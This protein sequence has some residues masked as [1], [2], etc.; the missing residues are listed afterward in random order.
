VYVRNLLSA[1]TN[2]ISIAR[3][4]AGKMCAASGCLIVMVVIKMVEFFWETCPSKYQD[5]SYVCRHRDER[6]L[7]S[8]F[9]RAGE[10]HV[11]FLSITSHSME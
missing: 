10:S 5:L 9:S 3:S 8:F 4:F 2:L 1:I 11:G 6:Q 7:D